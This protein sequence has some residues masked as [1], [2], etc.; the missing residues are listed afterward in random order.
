MDFFFI[1][2]YWG[3]NESKHKYRLT[4]LWTVGIPVFH[5]L[6]LATDTHFFGPKQW[7]HFRSQK[8]TYTLVSI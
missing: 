7:E 1:G 4:K 2:R 3:R 8:D 5:L 6:L